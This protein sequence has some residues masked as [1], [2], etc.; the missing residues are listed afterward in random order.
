M[1]GGD[2]EDPAVV[3]RLLRNL[4][5]YS[6]K[7]ATAQRDLA[8]ARLWYIPIA[9]LLVVWAQVLGPLTA[10]PFLW[11]EWIVFGL[12]CGIAAWLG[13]MRVK[14]HFDRKDSVQLA[15]W[16]LRRIYELASRVEDVGRGVDPSRRLELD[17][18][19]G[20]AQYLLNH[21]ERL[22]EPKSKEARAVLRQGA[23]PPTSAPNA[24]RAAVTQGDDSG[25]QA[26]SSDRPVAHGR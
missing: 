4:S 5:E 17:L 15:A 14:A 16:R 18:R 9:A 11:E 3:E 2:H 10:S 7:L 22:G 8:R 23:P 13:H 25:S 21:A 6:D 20:E 19:L 1:S 12:A 24:Q 26:N